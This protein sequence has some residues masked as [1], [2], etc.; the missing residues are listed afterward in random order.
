V[1]KLTTV[2]TTATE[3]DVLI[4]TTGSTGNITAHGDKI[5]YVT[6]PAATHPGQVALRG[7]FLWAEPRLTNA[8]VVD[9]CGFVVVRGASITGALGS[10]FQFLGCRAS[11]V[12]DVVATGNASQGAASA[13]AAIRG[14]GLRV[15]RITTAAGAYSARGIFIGNDSFAVTSGTFEDL[16]D[17]GSANGIWVTKTNASSFERLTSSDAFGGTSSDGAITT[18]ANV[19]ASSFEDLTVVN[20]AEDG[21]YLYSTDSTYRRLRVS[22]AGASGLYL[23]TARGNRVEDVRLADLNRTTTSAAITLACA[24][25]VLQNV[26]VFGVSN[27]LTISSD[28]QNVRLANL[29]VSGGDRPVNLSTNSSGGGIVLQNVTTV[30]SGYRPGVVGSTGTGVFINSSANKL[31][32]NLLALNNE[33]GMF[34]SGALGTPAP[35]VRNFVALGSSAEALGIADSSRT[36]FD[37]EVRLGKDPA[38]LACNVVPGAIGMTETCTNEA[39]STATVSLGL[40]DNATIVGPVTSDAANADDAAGLASYSATLDNMNFESTARAWGTTGAGTWPSVDQQG[41]CETGDTCQIYDLSLRSTD[42]IARNLA[43][44]PGGDDVLVMSDRVLAASPASQSDCDTYSPG[45]VFVAGAPNICRSTFLRDSVELLFDGIGDDD[46]LCESSETCLFS[47]NAGA[48]QGH[49]ALV[50]AGSFVDGQIVGVTLLK[51]ETNGR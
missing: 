1:R 41:R 30:N 13:N 6:D 39:P 37:G 3:H 50:S 49:G 21:I 16:S 44:L 45:S 29:Y 38:G 28:S 10:G 51:Y 4:T 26:S 48:Y 36:T 17:T 8:F 33:R 47:P 25:N 27:G 12:E 14:S 40:A 11:V 9:L 2:T 34:V 35:R 32:G 46:N 43:S 20:A 15:A 7:N 22:G 5:A 31:I 42:T 24:W 23:R 19:T 18:G